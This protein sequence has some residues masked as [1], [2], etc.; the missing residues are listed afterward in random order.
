[1]TIVERDGRA[2]DATAPLPVCYGTTGW[3]LRF[4]GR[5]TLNGTIIETF[6]RRR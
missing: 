3:S 5:P 4:F 6:V 1:M 2:I